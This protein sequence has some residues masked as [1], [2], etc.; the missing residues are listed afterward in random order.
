MGKHTTLCTFL[1]TPHF[2]LPNTHSLPTFPP[3]NTSCSSA[4]ARDCM[5]C[6]RPAAAASQSSPSPPCSARCL[7]QAGRRGESGLA[8]TA[9]SEGGLRAQ[10][11]TLRH[12]CVPAHPLPPWPSRHC[13]RVCTLR[14][15]PR[16]RLFSFHCSPRA[17]HSVCAVAHGRLRP[18]RTALAHPRCPRHAAVDVV[19]G[20]RGT[21]APCSKG[22]ERSSGGGGGGGSSYGW[23]WQRDGSE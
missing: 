20:S 21:C 9:G 18:R 16:S 2:S 3:R 15:D 5:R 4:C 19:A 6:G 13:D 17:A 22:R 7:D 11:R 14:F 10:W 23:D 1:P 12:W 8:A